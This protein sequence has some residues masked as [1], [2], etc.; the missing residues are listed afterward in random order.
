MGFLADADLSINRIEQTRQRAAQRG[1]IDL[2]SSNPTQQGLLF[3]PDILRAASEGYW[4][5]RRYQPDAHGDLRARE[6]IARYYT[7]RQIAHPAQLS[8][9]NT[10]I[11]ASTSEAYSLLF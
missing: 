9:Q 10:F 2:T 5:S 8:A 1:Y 3:P 7:Q 11:T 6:A 4:Q